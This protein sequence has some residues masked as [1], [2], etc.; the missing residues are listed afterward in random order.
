MKNAAKY[1]GTKNNGAAKQG[2]IAFP[3]AIVS[4]KT[5]RCL[6]AP[7]HWPA[8][9]AGV[10]V[11]VLSAAL[12]AV[13]A[14][15]PASEAPP[16]ASVAETNDAE[17]IS[18]L[19]KQVDSIGSEW[20]ADERIVRQLSLNGATPE[21]MKLVGHLRGLQV[22]A[23]FDSKLRSA[24]FAPV[25]ELT[26]LE[27]VYLKRTPIEAMLFQHL[28]NLPSLKWLIISESRIASFAG[29]ERL[30]RLEVLEIKVCSLPCGRLAPLEKLTELRQLELFQVGVVDGDLVH[31]QR[32]KKLNTLILTGNK[33]TNR[34][35]PWLARMTWLDD[36][37]VSETRVIEQG[38]EW[39]DKKLPRTLVID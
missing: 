3:A 27:F 17:I 33:I 21:A 24:D 36:L 8:V 7:A 14:A 29:L 26:D 16:P 20:D 28:A 11:V 9:A 10:T 12:S 15:P 37:W 19:E 4:R 30:T 39:L 22:L 2:T 32:L 13:C 23:V 35:L 31:L 25:A 5:C 6:K 38:A 18:A 34:S 1:V